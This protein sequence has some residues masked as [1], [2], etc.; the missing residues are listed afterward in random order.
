VNII[1]GSLPEFTTFLEQW[2]ETTKLTLKP[3]HDAWLREA[4]LLLYG[5]TGLETLAKAEGYKRPRVY[6]DWMQAFVDQKKYR[7]ALN[8][9]DIALNQLPKG[10]PLRAAI[11]DLMTFC[12]EQLQDGRVQFD[13]LWVSFKAKP[14]LTKLIAL[15]ES[16]QNADRTSLMKQ[17]AEVIEAHLKGSNRDS[18]A[19]NWEQDDLERPSRVTKTLLLHAYLFADDLAKA[20]ELAKKAASLGW[21]TDNPQP[22]FIAYCL[23]HAAKM[24]LSKLPNHLKQFWDYALRTSDDSVWIIEDHTNETARRLESTYQTIFE[25]FHDI[26]EKILTWCLT[27]SHKRVEDIVVNQHRKAYDRAALVTAAC[28]EALKVINPEEAT[29]FFWEIQSKFP[30]H[31]SFQ[32]EL[33]R[34]NIVQGFQK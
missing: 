31:S 20:L 34:V 30:R 15:Y 6:V 29:K 4:T 24:P 26:D 19:R 5:P 10:I 17:A 32:A 7:E 3:S 13:G 2:I 9:A 8:V 33:G 18:F 28:T 25:T 21:S 12:G 16:A 27:A 23:I 11:G 1:P 14:S 22:L